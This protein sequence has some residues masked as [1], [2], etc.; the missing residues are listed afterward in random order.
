MD[1]LRSSLN[2]HRAELFDNTVKARFYAARAKSSGESC[3]SLV[4]ELT[5]KASL[6]DDDVEIVGES[7]SSAVKVEPME[8][9]PL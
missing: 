8:E 4:A 1:V 9:T 2:F 5:S 3:D 7:S 6:E